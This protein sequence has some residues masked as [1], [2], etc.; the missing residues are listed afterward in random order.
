MK[1]STLFLALIS[2][3]ALVFAATETKLNTQIVTSNGLQQSEFKAPFSSE[4]HDATDIERSGSIGLYDYLSKHSSITVL[5][6]YGNPLTQN[7][8]MR[9]F[10]IENGHQNIVITINGRRLNNVDMAPQLLS[11]IPLSSIERIEI[12]KGSGAVAYGDGAMAGVI[13]IITKETSGGEVNRS[14]E[15]R[16][17]KE[18]RAGW[19]SNHE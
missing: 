1:R 7:L 18:C 12:I 8:D 10:G 4:I 2:T 5:P 17:G 9:G 11:N 16:V 15:R 6:S 19:V 3:P 13:N 14:E